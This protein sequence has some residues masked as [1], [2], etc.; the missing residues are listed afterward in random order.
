VSY[1]VPFVVALAITFIMGLDIIPILGISVGAAIGVN[2]VGRSEEKND[3]K[4]DRQ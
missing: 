2:L 3:N 1:I 4:V